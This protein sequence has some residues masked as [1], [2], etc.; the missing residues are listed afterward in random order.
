MGRSL[1]PECRFSA[2]AEEPTQVAGG[3]QS[4]SWSMSPLVLERRS[5]RGGDLEGA[6]AQCPKQSPDFHIHQ[7]P[8]APAAFSAAGHSPYKQKQ[9]RNRRQSTQRRRL[10]CV[11]RAP[12][13]GDLKFRRILL[14]LR[15]KSAQSKRRNESY[16]RL[17]KGSLFFST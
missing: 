5:L 1:S 7:A 8:P 6:R 14:R 9:A 12:A 15:Q 3:L 10:R 17:K 16:G 13:L 4:G 11:N 2:E